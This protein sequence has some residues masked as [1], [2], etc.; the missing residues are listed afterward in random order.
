MQKYDHELDMTSENS[1][2]LVLREIKMGSKVLEL[3]P[4]TG[5]MTRYMKEQLHC[6]V[7]CIEYDSIS[8]KQASV[9]SEKIIVSDLEKI[10]VWTKQLSGEKFDYIL[11]VDVL[12][13]LRDPHRVLKEV[14]QY[15]DEEGT[16]ITSIPNISHNAII[17]SLLQGEFKYNQ[18]GL[19]DNTHVK[20]FTKESII[21][22]LGE[23]GLEIVKMNA[24]KARPEETEFH[25]RYDE[26]PESIQDL[27][28]SNPEGHA[29]QYISVAKKMSSSHK[30]SIASF[31]ISTIEPI[32]DQLQVFWSEDGD[33]S[34]EKSVKYHMH[35]DNKYH[36]YKIA[37]PSVSMKKLRIDPG[38][39]SAFIDIKSIKLVK[40]DGSNIRII[41]ESSADNGFAH[42]FVANHL[43][44]IDK[45]NELKVF[46][47]SRDP[48][49]IWD[50][51]ELSVE[52]A[53]EL[54]IELS[55]LKG[56]L[57]V[58]RME[59][60]ILD[61]N[62]R[63]G[64]L[65]QQYNSLNNVYRTLEEKYEQLSRE[66]EVEIEE[67]GVLLEEHQNQLD[68]LHQELETEQKMNVQLRTL[69]EEIENSRSWRMTKPL[70]HVGYLYR[71]VRHKVSK[72]ISLV[73]RRQFIMEQ[74]PLHNLKSID[75]DLWESI[76]VDPSF[77][78]RGKF[79]TGWVLMKATTLTEND[80]P[81][82]L[83]WDR[84][85]GLSEQD[86]ANVGTVTHGPQKEQTFK[87]L[88]PNDAISLR[89]DPG[90]EP[91]RFLLR[92]LRFIKISKYHVFIDSLRN[93]TR[94]RGG[95]IRSLLPLSRKAIS[96]LKRSGL[97]GLKSQAKRAL[98]L[99]KTD[100]TQNYQNWVKAKKLTVNRIQEIKH[101][102]SQFSYNPLI[103][104]IVP[105][106]NVDEKWLRKCIESVRNQLY[107][108]WE[109]CIADDAS[110]K[111]HIRE[112]LNEYM[113]L[114]S[115]IKVVFREENG[116][117]SECSNSALAIANGEFVGLLDHDDELAIDALYENVKLLNKHPNADLI[118]SDEDKITEE[119]ERHSP[120][121]KPDWSPDLLLSQMYICH[122]SIYRK[123][124][125]DQIG[126]F[127][128]GYE[129]SQD[130]D[131]ALRFTE[132]TDAIYHIPKIL[133][134]WRTIP[135]STASGAVA[136]NYSDD[137]GY[138]ALQDAVIRRGLNAK[139]E[140]IDIPNAYILRYQPIGDPLVS[141]IIPTRNMADILEKCLI[142]IFT[143][144]N[145]PNFEVII[146]DNGSNEEET[147]QLFNKWMEK[148]PNRFRV[149]RIDIPFNYS[150]INN[151]AVSEAKGDLI[152]LLNNDVEVISENWITD[153]AGQAVREQIG[154][155]GACL[156]YPDNT[157]QHAGV[158]LGIGGVAGHS[159][160]Y[161]DA[162]DYGYFSR[163][164]LIS[165]YSAVTAACLM[166]R[167]SIFEEV[168]GLEEDL[169]VAFNDIDFCLKIREKG[170]Y[171]IF[172]P[173]V[174]LYHYESKSR[175]H[176]DTPEKIRRFNSEVDYMKK[177]WG[178]QLEND[179][180]YNV[181]L[182]KE[183]EDFS[184]GFIR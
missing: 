42:L 2:T 76:G 41:Q 26:F 79:P 63:I 71:T 166:V 122:F 157:I 104:I 101:E 162:E 105:V 99:S 145:Y 137:S 20:F 124:I 15:L 97:T 164:R 24:T 153:M 98:G 58:A 168:G 25:K 85:N 9:Y 73:S 174:K 77:I 134:H 57:L 129:G 86:S 82:K 80:M 117:I 67:K 66:L 3:G 163:L 151:N 125:I 74:I 132:I 83:Y 161:F 108:N 75:K 183:R 17:M 36:V 52:G 81:L 10:S 59:S 112:V 88:I 14:V 64:N 146:A 84:G 180:F 60:V 107:P 69:V 119:G 178:T 100:L 173:Q 94:M 171:N 147:I 32:Y 29:Y 30:D 167:K 95:I 159:H 50:F 46:A 150:R 40:I 8:A 111:K 49:I 1:A 37:I 116:H 78:L 179:P 53:F 51:P 12:E 27:L 177:K 56:S 158:V 21:E 48:Q 120:F 91:N 143:K 154:A 70:R 7:Y 23:A 128:K 182:T 18:L 135:E 126:G 181:N 130:Y 127:R 139:V 113:Q 5:Y 4:A 170:Y 155:V 133:Y 87:V 55:A 43:T 175:G 92:D 103:S 141:I 34:E 136:K 118:Y 31:P 106:Y 184:L 115:R 176:E 169:Q 165:N 44:V 156:L 93:Y 89:L 19:L 68:K 140:R 47:S 138:K 35:Y 65:D 72:F 131:L 38:S 109:L 148:E 11:C 6:S 33:F 39:W 90:E 22:M 121:F 142:S 152:L 149:I 123:S 172:L 16:V 54:W 96:I 160:K 144:T 28:L 114:D 102:I 62:T 13:H 61:Y 110:P 45:E